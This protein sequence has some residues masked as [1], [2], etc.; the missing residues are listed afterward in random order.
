MEGANYKSRLAVGQCGTSMSTFF[1]H[2]QAICMT[3][4]NCVSPSV[5]QVK[6]AQAVS[7]TITHV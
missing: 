5:M 4:R 6:V 1:F 7:A 3:D 2:R